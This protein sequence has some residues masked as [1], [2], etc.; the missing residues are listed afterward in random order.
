MVTIT[1]QGIAIS[2]F[3]RRLSI[4]HTM[5]SNFKT[6][7]KFS[8]NISSE[9]EKLKLGGFTDDEAKEILFLIDDELDKITKDL[10]TQDKL[11]I[12]QTKFHDQISAASAFVTSTSPFQMNFSSNFPSLA[13]G[14]NP[15]PTIMDPLLLEKEIKTTGQQLSDEIKQLQADY[16]LDLNL[17]TKRREEVDAILEGKLEAASDY[18]SRRLKDLNDHLDKVASQALASIGGT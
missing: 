9:I 2:M 7:R 4:P 16:Q 3:L 1:K 11:K 15:F 17:E 13:G 5:L 8:S 14:S 10:A 18:A 12:F 6:I